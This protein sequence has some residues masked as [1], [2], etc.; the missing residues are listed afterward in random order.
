[1]KAVA[2]LAGLAWVLS[3]SAA[4][5]TVGGSESFDLVS[6]KAEPIYLTFEYSPTVT[7]QLKK[8]LI[9]AGYNIVDDEDQAA[10][11]VR[12]MGAYVFQRTRA[13]EMFAD[14]GK[15][16]ESGDK[17]LPTES[18][19]SREPGIRLQPEAIGPMPFKVWLAQGILRDVLLAAGVNSWFNKLLVGDERGLCV[20]TQ[21]MCKDWKK[22]AQETRLQTIISPK[23]GGEKIVRSF[24]RAKDEQLL[25]AELFQASLK[26]M[27]SRLSGVDPN[28]SAK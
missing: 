4:E 1:M 6:K 25:P 22:F 26:E 2:L 20:G 7:A 24:A 3:A 8:E 15:V 12:M 23:T 14:M 18:D 13:K 10:F 17:A 28:S 21:E 27:A 16:L 11:T 9:D 5:V 19:V